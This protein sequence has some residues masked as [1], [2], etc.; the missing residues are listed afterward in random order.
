MVSALGNP[1]LSTSANLSGDP[2]L[3]NP[4]EIEASL[5]SFTDL[6]LDSGVIHQVPSTV[7][8][9]VGDKVEVLREGAGAAEYFKEYL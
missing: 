4:D 3:G 9:L 5:G 7:V 6:I 1:V 2:P 8:S